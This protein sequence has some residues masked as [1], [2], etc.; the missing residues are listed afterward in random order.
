[1]DCMLAELMIDPA[2][3]GM[4]MFEAT[5]VVVRRRTLLTDVQ[6]LIWQI[7][8]LETGLYS[9]NSGAPQ[10]YKRFLEHVEK[11]F[12][13]SHPVSAIFVS[14]NPFISTITYRFRLEDLPS[15]ADKLHGGFTLHIPPLSHASVADHSLVDLLKSKEHLQSITT[16]GN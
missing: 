1:M 3:D 14:D 13:L 5:D 8:A 16:S 15:Y 12:P 10:R 9:N 6:T 11:F 7:G 4:Q 2:T